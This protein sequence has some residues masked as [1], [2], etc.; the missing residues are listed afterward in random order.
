MENSFR[1]FL[2]NFNILSKN[3]FGFKAKHSTTDALISITNQIAKSLDT[4]M[5]SVLVTFDLKKAFDCVDHN[6]MI[7][8]LKPYCDIKTIKWFDSYLDR[9][10]SFVCYN[11]MLSDPGILKLSVPQGGCLAPLLFILYMN[12][13]AELPLNGKL[14]LFADDMSLVVEAKTY[15]DLQNKLNSDLL[16]INSWLKNNRLV[17]NYNKTNFMVMGNPRE[18]SI[19]CIKPYINNNQLNRVY[20]TKILG[21]EFDHNLKF[22][23]HINKLVKELN[24]RF[25]LFVRL[26]KFLPESILNMLYKSMVRPK[27]EYGCVVFGHTYDTHLKSLEVI[28]KKFS[29]LITNSDPYAHSS[30]IKNA[31]KFQSILYIYKS[32]NGLCSDYTKT[33]FSINTN[34]TSGRVGRDSLSISVPT[35]KKNFFKNIIFIKG[36][37]MWNSMDLDIRSEP[38]LNEFINRLETLDFNEL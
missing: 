36:A 27:L 38:D 7:N 23:K 31:I 5:K 15:S 28:Q 21:I 10:F 17:L 22:D 8:K 16:Q 26:K 14:Y 11:K 35:V 33:L 19:S 6:I 29:R 2:I 30:P 25:S 12:D 13:I 3:Q 24:S 9:R 34:R 20:S 18:S 37:D 32:I 4:N 1:N